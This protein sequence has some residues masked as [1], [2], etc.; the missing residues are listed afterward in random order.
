L[1]DLQVLQSPWFSGNKCQREHLCATCEEVQIYFRFICL[2]ISI[3]N[4]IRG[5]ETRINVYM[6]KQ[7][8]KFS[9]TSPTD[10]LHQETC[11]HC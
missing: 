10:V 9:P 2:I 3:V 8:H 6:L 7:N 11:S 5:K 1:H 4:M